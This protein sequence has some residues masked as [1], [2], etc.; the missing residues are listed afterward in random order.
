MEP[1]EAKELFMRY[2]KLKSVLRWTE[3]EV[4]AIVKELGYLALAITL[5][6]SYVSTT[7]RLLSDIRQYVPEYHRP[8]QILLSQKPKRL[9]HQYSQSVLTTEQVHYFNFIA[10]IRHITECE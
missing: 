5:T 1:S 2:S 8:R 3:V 9:I 7:Q 6:G 10:D 4:N